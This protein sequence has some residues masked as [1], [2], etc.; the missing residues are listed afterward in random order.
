MVTGLF[1]TPPCN[2]FSLM[3]TFDDVRP[4]SAGE[5]DWAVS[6]VRRTREMHRYFEGAY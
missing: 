2:V 5:W 3:R 6:L 4:P 1:A